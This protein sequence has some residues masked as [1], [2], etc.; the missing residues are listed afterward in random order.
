MCLAV[1]EFLLTIPFDLPRD[2]KI[3]LYHDYKLKQYDE[4]LFNQLFPKKEEVKVSIIKPKPKQELVKLTTYL[5]ESEA[6]LDTVISDYIFIAVDKNETDAKKIFHKIKITDM[7]QLIQ[8]TRTNNH[9]YE[10]I[11][12]DCP[13]KPYF[14]LEME[15][16]GLTTEIQKEKL[17]LF[18]DWFIKEVN[19]VLEIDLNIDDMQIINSSRH[20]KLSYHLIIQNKMYFKNVLEQKHWILFLKQRFTN[21]TD[22]NKEIIQ[23]LTWN[24]KEETRYIFDHIPYSKN[25]KFRCINQSKKGKSYVLRN[26]SKIFG[27]RDS[28]VRLY[29]GVEDRTEV[30]VELLKITEEAKMKI[31][32]K[33]NKK[34]TV[35]CAN[36]NIDDSYK[37]DGLTLMEYKNMSYQDIEKLPELQQ[38]LF[39]IPNTGQSWDF[40]RNVGFAIKGAGGNVEL[41]R[42]WA[43]LSVK[44]FN[45]HDEIFQAFKGFK[46]GE[47]TYGLPFLKRHAKLSHPAFFKRESKVFN[48][49]FKIDLE[50]LTLIKEDC[51]FVSQE[52]TP[53]ENNIFHP[54]KHMVIH[55][56]LGRGKTTAIKRALKH[57][58]RYLFLSPRQTFARFISA[59][60]GIPCYLDKGNYCS[61]Q[62]VV[63]LESLMKVNNFAYD[64]IV[65]DECESILNQFS[66]PTLGANNVEV[67]NFLTFLISKCGRVIYA[68]AFISNRTLDFARSF[69]EDIVMIQNDTAP[70]KRKAVQ[71]SGMNF[72]DSLYKSIVN[73]EKNYV[74]YSSIRH[75]QEHFHTLLKS[76]N[77]LVKKTAEN[78]IV[79]HSKISDSVFNTLENINE[80]WGEASL[81]ITSPS[82][83]VGCS[84]SPDRPPDFNRVWIMASPTCCVRDTFQTQMRVRHLKDN[85]MVFSLPS[86]KSME[87][88][89][90]SCELEIQLLDE[91]E[92]FMDSKRTILVNLIDDIIKVNPLREDKLERIR[93][94]I[95]GGDKI[96][97]ALRKIYF[98][99]LL[100]STLSLRHYKNMFYSFLS[101]CGYEKM[102]GEEADENEDNNPEPVD[103][104]EIYKNTEKITWE[105]QIIIGDKIKNKKATDIEK[106]QN[107]IY[108]FD[109]KIKPDLP[110]DD[111]K[112]FYCLYASSGERKKW[113]E[114]MFI[115]G[116]KD[117]C[118]IMEKDFWNLKFDSNGFDLYD[119]RVSQF[120][121]IKQLNAFLGLPSSY[122]KG[123]KKVCKVPPTGELVEY[124]EAVR[125]ER[126]G[127]EKC[128]PYFENSK[129]TINNVFQF[130][131]EM[132]KGAKFNFKNSMD[133]LNKIYDRWSGGYFKTGETDRKKGKALYLNFTCDKNFESK[134]DREIFN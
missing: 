88:F 8:L 115:E 89:K 120:S 73:N 29:H 50:N 40:F 14:D 112:K 12:L 34:G 125:V 66:S 23:Q 93:G 18:I 64:C 86:E 20:N 114:N 38:Y 65:L 41:Y 31:Q 45:Y 97:D 92:E 5:V 42:N 24:Y 54:S 27:I 83:T 96:P 99:N 48:R 116:K 11:P 121:V 124:Y 56:Y 84:Y 85:E 35:V 51:P 103:Y 129:S 2:E 72:Y 60:F 70:V 53:H 69:G 30:N 4:W 28:F 67:F 90:S 104:G 82:N 119:M 3:R 43:S 62:L 113:F 61:D 126:K 106:Q 128:I 59:D 127:V 109:L 75:L 21:P 101:K 94:H 131:D 33:R 81:V 26:E 80:T 55:A 111:K 13:V 130:K 87:F 91:Y 71:I 98:Y 58:E 123:E 19:A 100:E 107:A 77:E 17:Q 105:Q 9:I 57:Y 47:G 6:M 117:V 118:G 10:S 132:K 76:D 7:E 15:Y 25:Q 108:W 16:E 52:N 36:T 46:T 79:Y 44:K 22:E 102:W 95:I 133:L 134:T 74:C 49:L 37:K 1:A 63:S 122:C 110:D 68:D 32:K 78:A 39:L